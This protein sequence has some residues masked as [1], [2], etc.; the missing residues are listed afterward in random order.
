[1]ITLRPPTIITPRL[2][3]GVRIGDVFVSIEYSRRPGSE[4]RT[5]YTYHVDLPAGEVTGYDLQSGA[6]GGTLQE[7]L[8]N[9][10]CF[11]EAA[12]ESYSYRLRTGRQGEN[13]DLFPPPVVEWAYQHSDE[14]AMTRLELEEDKTLIVE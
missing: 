5:R 4:G 9:L 2:L 11:L 8:E 3:P 6:G 10:L 7:G 14:I 1:V 12:A 13:E